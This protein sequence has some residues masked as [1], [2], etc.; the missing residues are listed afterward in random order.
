LQMLCRDGGSGSLYESYG[1]DFFDLVVFDDC[2]TSLGSWGGILS[3][4][5]QALQLGTLDA[6]NLQA[7]EYFGRAVYSY[8]MEQAINDGYL[9]P[10]LLES[11]LLTLGITK[12]G[13][14]QKD[15]FERSIA[16][17]QFTSVIAGD[18]WKSLSRFDKNQRKTIV[19]CL[20]NTH[21]EMMTAELKRMSRNPAIAVHIS[22]SHTDSQSFIERFRNS[23]AGNPRIAVAVDLLS[24]SSI[25]EVTNIVLARPIASPVVLSSLVALGARPCDSIDKR[26]FTVFDYCGS[27]RALNL[28][29]IGYAENERSHPPEPRLTAVVRKSD[30]WAEQLTSEGLSEVVN[31]IRGFSQDDIGHLFKS[32]ISREQRSQ[33]RSAIGTQ[34]QTFNNIQRQP[35]MSGVD[36]V[37]VLAKVVFGLEDVPTRK[38]RVINFWKKEGSWIRTRLGLQHDSNEDDGQPGSWKLAFWRVALDHFSLY[39]IDQLEHGRT[40]QLPQFVGQFG[41]FQTLTSKYGGPKQ[42]RADLESVK[43]KM[44]VPLVFSEGESE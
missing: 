17:A 44:Y 28:S 37:D 2:R 27:V 41:S 18:L 22:A 26:Y 10:F 38:D 5:E 3:H 43:E 14:L 20:N 1:G 29:W 16:T 15:Q 9:L 6:P 12:W 11:R 21:A 36:E 42:L 8:S 24:K 13:M 4:F 32:W 25:P 40:Y 23:G 30:Q 33:L 35:E 7:F 31:T 39:G 34:M 19:F